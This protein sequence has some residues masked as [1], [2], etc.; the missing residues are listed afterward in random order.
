MEKGRSFFNDAFTGYGIQVVGAALAFGFQ[1][2][3]AFVLDIDE[4]GQFNYYFGFVGILGVFLTLGFSLYIPKASSRLPPFK[5]FSKAITLFVAAFILTTP[6]TGYFLFIRIGELGVIFVIILSAVGFALIEYVKSTLVADGKIVSAYLSRM[7]WPYI[8]AIIL[9]IVVHFFRGLDAE[10]ALFVFGLGHLCVISRFF[11][12]S[13]Y[14]PIGL[15][16]K[17]AKGAV[18][19]FITQCVFFVYIPISRVLQVDFFG[20]KVGAVLGLGILFGKMFSMFGQSISLILMP[21]IASLWTL[22]NHS[23]VKVIYRRARR[24][25]YF[26]VMPPLIVTLINHKRLL[27]LFGEEYASYHWVFFIMILSS[28]VLQLLGPNGLILL[29]S[30]NEKREMNNGIILFLTFLA[31]AVIF[32]PLFPTGIAFAV[33]FSEVVVG[34][35]KRSAVCRLLRIST[36]DFSRLMLGTVFL[37]ISALS[38]AASF[39]GS[40]FVW[41]GLM[42]SLSFFGVFFLFKTSTDQDDR[43]LVNLIKYLK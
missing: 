23:D 12:T 8:L 11:Q 38:I 43:E 22:G 9:A 2:G 3:C 27:G 31:S 24:T 5:C 16:I 14:K 32:G 25:M 34:C 37:A 19:F 42:G 41:I 33:L 35:A 18:P 13:N 20:T 17:F 7:V 40:T 28:G 6:I 4:F 30:G 26:C 29:M 21:R 36:C 15:D 39:I 1:L 10:A